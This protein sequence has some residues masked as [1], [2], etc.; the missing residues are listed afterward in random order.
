M[1]II[2]VL[3]AT[4]GLIGSITAIG[5]D[6]WRK[7]HVQWRDRITGRGWVAIGCLISAFAL[8]VTKEVTSHQEAEATKRSR[9]AHDEKVLQELSSIKFKTEEILANES[10]HLTR[11]SPNPV[12]ESVRFRKLVREG[13]FPEIA[14]R[15]YRPTDR[16]TIGVNVRAQ[17]SASAAVIGRVTPGTPLRFLESAP[18][19]VRVQ[20]PSGLTGWVSKAWVEEIE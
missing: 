16:V 18:R 15:L 13:G 2:N 8:G 10:L 11:S 3:L 12:Q 20:D 7:G 19:W 4:F 9:A 14:E 6:T 1:I 17:P 5:G